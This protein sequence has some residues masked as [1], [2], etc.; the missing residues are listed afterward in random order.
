MSGRA[1]GE[2]W[3]TFT[4]AAEAER[5]VQERNRQHMGSRYVELFVYRN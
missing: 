1:S 4:S 5:A 3:V 2:A